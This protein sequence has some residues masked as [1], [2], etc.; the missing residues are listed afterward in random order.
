MSKTNL[1]YL[2]KW[3][4]I[5]PQTLILHRT[6]RSI[7]HQP[8][9]I[10]KRLTWRSIKVQALAK[11]LAVIYSQSHHQVTLT[12]PQNVQLICHR[13]IPTLKSCLWTDWSLTNRSSP[14]M[15][16]CREPHHCTFVLLKV[17]LPAV[18]HRA[19]LANLAKATAHDHCLLSRLKTPPAYLQAPKKSPAYLQALKKSL[20]YLQ[21]IATVQVWVQA[22]LTV[23]KTARNPR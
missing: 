16:R 15:D 5:T 10:A 12:L 2:S 18:I 7:R 13:D 3:L 8:A 6:R 19:V 21:T 20:A 4:L 14:T 22:V 11:Q 17:R 9:H 1:N 23:T